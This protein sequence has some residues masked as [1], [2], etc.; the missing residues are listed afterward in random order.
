M[1]KYLAVILLAC[2]AVVS[3]GEAPASTSTP[4]PQIVTYAELMSGIRAGTQVG[5]SAIYCGSTAS[6]FMQMAIA[7]KIRLHG[8]T[9]AIL[10]AK[11]QVANPFTGRLTNGEQLYS[12][13]NGSTG[14]LIFINQDG[15]PI[16]GA[17]LPHV[18][19][20]N[21]TKI[22]EAHFSYIGTGSAAVMTSEQFF[23][24][25]GVAKDVEE[26]RIRFAN[27]FLGRFITPQMPSTEGM[28]IGGEIWQA[29]NKPGTIHIITADVTGRAFVAQFH[30]AVSV[31][32]K[33]GAP[34]A[35]IMPVGSDLSPLLSGGTHPIVQVFAQ[36]QDIL[37][38]GPT[39]RL[40]IT[41]G[42]PPQGA[43]RGVEIW[44]FV[45]MELL[46][47]LLK[48]AVTADVLTDPDMPVGETDF[49]DIPRVESYAPLSQS[50]G[51][52]IGDQP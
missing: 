21:H 25:V 30:N 20:C 51:R 37:A 46:G 36:R 17:N 31:A 24:A 39:P 6:R 38:N 10:S 32:M 11:E 33:L 34:L 9:L 43:G 45:P 52:I 18:L 1:N 44:G 42:L 41:G 14:T 26:S 13:Y 5:P 22:I 16:Y 28:T 27:G 50:P 29:W 35:V 7:G 19:H 3:A 15:M 40:V 49:G 47:Q 48:K 23:N 12:L 4:V 8:V 2:S